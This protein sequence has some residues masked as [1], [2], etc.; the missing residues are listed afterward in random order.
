MAEI[1]CRIGHELDQA[2][3]LARCRPAPCG[4]AAALTR[5]WAPLVALLLAGAALAAG[6]PA[7]EAFPVVVASYTTQYP[8][9]QVGRSWNIDRAARRLD[10]AL[11][12][13]GQVLS[14]NQRVGPR[15]LQEAFRPAP[16]L[17]DGDRVE[18]IG[19]GVCQVASTLYAAALD[20]GLVVESRA[21]HSRASGY[22][23]TGRDATVSYES[24]IDLKLRNDL[25]FPILVRS[26]AEGGR[27]TVEWRAPRVPERSVSVAFQRSPGA[28]GDGMHVVTVRTLQS[29]SGPP[30]REV[31]AQDVYH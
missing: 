1:R 20:A 30:A 17:L 7:P 16:E 8:L 3:T 14:F 13:P 29:S 10:G 6:G 31:V 12:A 15:G 26:R 11:L 18:G 9:A 19:G 2:S 28:G 4:R 22:I 23:P 5:R 27:L 24:G 25:P 21:A